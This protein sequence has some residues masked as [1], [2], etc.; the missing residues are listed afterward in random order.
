MDSVNISGVVVVRLFFGWLVGGF[1]NYAVLLCFD[2]LCFCFW[3]TLCCTCS[4]VVLWSVTVQARLP[5][6]PGKGVVVAGNLFV[7]V[8]AFFRTVPC[9]NMHI[10]LLLFG[11]NLC[12]KVCKCSYDNVVL[13][14]L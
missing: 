3:G 4:V 1:L 2:H 10:V 6:L 13:T 12:E 11:Q 14:I 8:P 5:P 9:C 7:L